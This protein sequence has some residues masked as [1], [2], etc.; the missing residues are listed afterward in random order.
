MAVRWLAR[1]RLEDSVKAVAAL[2]TR[3]A[4]GLSGGWTS[5]YLLQKLITSAF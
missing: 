4:Q 2:A 1:A 5:R 3:L